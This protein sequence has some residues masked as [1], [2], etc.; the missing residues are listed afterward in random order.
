M[1]CGSYRAWSAQ[2][3]RTLQIKSGAM[4]QVSKADEAN[5]ERCG[6]NRYTLY[7]QA[8]HRASYSARAC[9]GLTVMG[10][11]EE[12]AAA[13]QLIQDIVERCAQ[14]CSCLSKSADAHQISRTA[15]RRGGAKDRLASGAVVPGFVGS[16]PSLDLDKVQ[17]MLAVPNRHV[18]GLIGRG[19]EVRAPWHLAVACCV[20]SSAS[21]MSYEPLVS[22]ST[23]EFTGAW[24]WAGVR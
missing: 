6:V 8:A 18:G 15:T 20:E 19:G 10:P 16:A 21:L 24:G 1:A 23:S 4:I 14:H 5:G 9:R 7:N 2:S 11:P 12:V 17:Y 13:K 22:I 3:F